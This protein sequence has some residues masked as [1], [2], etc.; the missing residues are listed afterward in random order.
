VTATDSGSTKD[1][2]ERREDS[3][4]T[5]PA[6][7]TELAVPQQDVLYQLRE[8]YRTADGRRWLHTLL[9][10]ASCY[11]YIPMFGMNPTRMGILMA[12]RGLS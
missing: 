7:T 1:L 11:E 9:H 2:T 6:S 5:S 4:R 8:Q 10:S 12:Q 3:D